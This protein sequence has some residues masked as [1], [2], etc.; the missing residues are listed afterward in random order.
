MR[1]TVLVLIF[2]SC[3]AYGQSGDARPAFEA[4]SLKPSP[5]GVPVRITGG[6]GTTDPGQFTCTNWS[7][8]NLLLR[9]YR[10]KYYQL[11]APA[12][13]SDPSQG[14]SV[15]AKIPAG[16]T[17][18]QM[19]LMLQRLLEERFQLKL[20]REMKEMATYELVASKGGAK[21]TEVVGAPAPGD[22]IKPGI[23]KDGFPIVP[24]GTGIRVLNGRARIQFRAQTM[25]NFAL[26]LTAQ[27][28]RPV[29]DATGLSGKYAL[30]LSWYTGNGD[31][32]PDIFEAM[33]KQLGL[34]LEPK[35]GMVE[36]LVIDHA[37]KVPIEN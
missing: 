35:R 14:F 28:D 33:Q 29:I 37:E 19:R 7:L 21:L 12:W 11:S 22:A 30:T 24:G 31:P 20:H 36:M 3:T 18:E 10:V 32:G 17:G 13:V 6:P 25:D 4:A 15:A 27:V 26:L 8:S 23:D 9:A 2:M 16:T 34:R 1:R 5:A